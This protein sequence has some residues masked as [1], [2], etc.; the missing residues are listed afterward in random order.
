MVHTVDPFLGQRP[1]RTSSGQLC[2]ERAQ[3]G[4][5]A[6]IRLPE[7]RPPTG[8][9]PALLFSPKAGGCR[10]KRLTTCQCGFVIPPQ[11][12]PLALTY[13]SMKNFVGATP[14]ASSSLPTALQHNPDMV[15]RCCRE[16]LHLRWIF[17]ILRHLS[18]AQETHYV[19]DTPALLLIHHLLIY[20]L[21]HQ[22]TYHWD[23]SCNRYTKSVHPCL[24]YVPSE[25]KAPLYL[26]LL[27][28]GNQALLDLAGLSW[29][30][31]PPSE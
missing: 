22:Y 30:C 6:G 16:R 13:I 26:L 27:A 7:P 19:A 9:N 12:C 5:R 17:P 14:G 11:P 8:H 31:L 2:V 23:A 18:S 24:A 15:L 3:N 21:P 29:P 1:T 10:K 4:C 25:K 28:C 20:I